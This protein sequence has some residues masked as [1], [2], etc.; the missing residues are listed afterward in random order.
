[1]QRVNDALWDKEVRFKGEF[2]KEQQSRADDI[3]EL[4]GILES[5]VPHL[6]GLIE[7]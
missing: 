1:M 6:Q 4:K 7:E 5:D 2:E 3:A